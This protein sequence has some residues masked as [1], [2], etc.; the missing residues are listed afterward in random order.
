MGFAPMSDVRS[1]PVN[2]AAKP[3]KS[4]VAQSVGLDY[5]IQLVGGDEA[6]RDEYPMPFVYE[7]RY[8]LPEN[9]LS[10][11]SSWAPRFSAQEANHE[12]LEM[13]SADKCFNPYPVSYWP[14]C[15]GG[16][17]S[18]RHPQTD[19]SGTDENWDEYPGLNVA[20]GEDVYGQ[21]FE[22][23]RSITNIHSPQS[24]SGSGR[25]YSSAYSAH[26]QNQGRH[27]QHSSSP[28]SPAHAGNSNRYP[29]SHSPFPY[30][31]PSITDPEEAVPAPAD[32]YSQSELTNCFP[33][34]SDLQYWQVFDK[35]NRIIDATPT[36]RR[37]STAACLFCKSRKIG[38]R[39]PEGDN[40][41]QTCNQCAK[42]DRVCQYPNENRRGQHARRRRPTKPDTVAMA[43][44][45]L[46]ESV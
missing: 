27:A 32:G 40:A 9:L 28:V 1:Q 35:G 2:L 7:P 37:P 20:G 29:A 12:Y 13:R 16:F 33:A 19:T 21:S 11:C 36:A 46:P 30:H 17:V 5:P 43:V 18:E 24:P 14:N 42:R 25:F 22:G 3:A 4:T 41:N 6:V 15:D 8:A 39:K 34:S 23:N 44:P 10:N 31:Q 45:T 26:P 38:C